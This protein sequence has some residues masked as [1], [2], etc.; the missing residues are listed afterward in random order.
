[1]REIHE[2]EEDQGSAERSKGIGGIAGAPIEQNADLGNA[3]TSNQS[4]RQIIEGV[5][6]EG[7]SDKTPIEESLTYLYYS[8]GQKCSYL[9]TIWSS[10]GFLISN[11][12]SPCCLS[13]PKFSL[14]KIT[15]IGELWFCVPGCEGC[16]QK[17]RHA[18]Y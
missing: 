12:V 6:I 18:L 13:L 11:R 5:S 4:G 9:N 7:V 15:Q 8:T 1:M 14:H 16:F 2:D 10:P 3:E 17:F